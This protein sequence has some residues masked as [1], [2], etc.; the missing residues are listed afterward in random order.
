MAA[1]KLGC[2]M[3]NNVRPVLDGAQQPGGGKG[4]VHHQGDAV[5]V[6]QIRQRFNIH[7]IAVRVAQGLNK[8]G[9]GA[10]C[11]GAF[12]SAGFIGVHKGG[13]YA[14]GL[15]RVRQQIVGAAVEGFFGHDVV[16]S[17]GQILQGIGNGCCAAGRGQGSN[18]AFKR[19][20]PLFKG[21]LRGIGQ[22][23]VYVA[24]IAEVKASLSVRTVVKNKGC[25][26][27]DRYGARAC[28]RIRLFLPCMN[29]QGFKTWFLFFA[30]FSPL[31]LLQFI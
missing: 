19:S 20:H 9:L 6:G 3:H 25:C 10:R 5:F 24:G 21:V 17:F 8:N 15:E 30:H 14:P 16:A 11:D 23:A 4:I 7:N 29:L 31:I 12:K 22:A 27:I 2:R 28:S 26:L 1:N 13:V 18:A